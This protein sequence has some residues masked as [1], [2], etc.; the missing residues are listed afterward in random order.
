MLSLCEP[1]ADDGTRTFWQITSVKQIQL[2]PFLWTRGHDRNAHVYGDGLSVAFQSLFRMPHDDHSS[3]A[4]LLYRDRRMRDQAHRGRIRR[5]SSMPPMRTGL[6]SDLNRKY[7]LVLGFTTHG[8]NWVVPC[9]HKCLLDGQ[10]GF[11]VLGAFHEHSWRACMQGC[12]GRMDY[13][14]MF[15][16]FLRYT[17]SRPKRLA[18]ERERLGRIIETDW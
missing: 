11:G 12:R 8:E 16:E 9:F 14:S 6:R 2:K 7:S 10:W 4:L 3:F 1:N 18:I 15:E 17:A 5:S 13:S